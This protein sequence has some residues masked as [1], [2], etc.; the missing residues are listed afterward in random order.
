MSS[1]GHETDQN[2]VVVAQNAVPLH[3]TAV[4]TTGSQPT[5]CRR[6]QASTTLFARWFC[7]KI[8]SSTA[9]LPSETRA[10][11]RSVTI[12]AFGTIA[13]TSLPTSS[14]V[15]NQAIRHSD[16]MLAVKNQ[17]Q[18]PHVRKSL[19]SFFVNREFLY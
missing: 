17:P 10:A 3:Q 18:A 19:S 11:P 6:T 4:P 14:A 16:T 5:R 1:E 7:R 2:H 9:A 13:S 12:C 8:Q 15:G